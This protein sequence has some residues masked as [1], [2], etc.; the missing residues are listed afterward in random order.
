MK[1]FVMR[2]KTASGGKK[3]KVDVLVLDSHNIL[4]LFK[5]LYMSSPKCPHGLAKVE[6][7]RLN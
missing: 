2:N 6:K 5:T 3:M 4:K 7:L 1:K